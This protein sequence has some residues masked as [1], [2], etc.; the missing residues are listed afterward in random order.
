MNKHVR[1]ISAGALL[2]LAV[3]A[4]PALAAALPAPAPFVSN[5]DVRCYK[6]PNQPPLN[7]T[8]RLDHLNPYF[9]QQQ[10]P[11]EKVT[12]QEPQDLCVPVYKEDRVPPQ[13][14]LPFLQY[15]DWKCY[16]ITGPSLDLPV[17]LDQLNP[18]IAGLFG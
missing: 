14:V 12:L 6:I 7:K 15:V 3:V 10:L 16:G 18:V 8:L 4:L 11:F 5:L 1:P 13:D 2:L 17:H 9:I